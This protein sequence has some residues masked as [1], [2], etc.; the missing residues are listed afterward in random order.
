MVFVANPPDTVT[1]GD[2]RTLF[3]DVTFSRPRGH[4][5]RAYVL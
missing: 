5:H 2:L 4:T 1:E 3:K